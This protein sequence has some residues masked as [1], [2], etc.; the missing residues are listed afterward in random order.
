MAAGQLGLDNLAV[1]VDD[2]QHDGPTKLIMGYAPLADKW[3]AFGWHVT[4]VD[5]HDCA[6]LATALRPAPVP[7]VVI[8]RTIKGRGVSF[9]EGTVEWHSVCDPARLADAVEELSRA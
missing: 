1:I 4:E 7:K 3:R 6:Q 9:M 8:A 2:I 5:G